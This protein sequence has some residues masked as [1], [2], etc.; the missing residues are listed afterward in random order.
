MNIVVYTS[1]SCG[2][3]KYLKAKMQRKNV[4]YTE[5]DID[6]IDDVK[7]KQFE[8]LHLMELPIVEIDGKILNFTEANT[9][10]DKEG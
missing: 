7:R 1:P 4:E 6:S 2:R 9:V 3:C 8:D 5:I 10:I